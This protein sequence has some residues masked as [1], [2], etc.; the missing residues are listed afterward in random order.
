M[1]R[2]SLLIIFT[3]FLS[4][5][6]IQSSTLAT[7]VGC[8][9]TVIRVPVGLGLPVSSQPKYWDANGTYITDQNLYLYQTVTVYDVYFN[10]TTGE[11][12]FNIGTNMWAMAKAGYTTDWTSIIIN[13]YGCTP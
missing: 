13:S 1:K 10:R 8:P 7:G 11:I 6:P 5:V 2:L 4:L 3:V 9:A 12:W